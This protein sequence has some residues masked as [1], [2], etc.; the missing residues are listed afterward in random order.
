MSRSEILK[1]DLQLHGSRCA[2]IVSAARL[3]LGT[4]GPDRRHH[5]KTE[6]HPPQNFAQRGRIG[7]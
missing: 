7:W 1:E 5:N 3:L 4:Q 2:Q 6:Q